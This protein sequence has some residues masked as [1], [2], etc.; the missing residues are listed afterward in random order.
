MTRLAE[1]PSEVLLLIIEQFSRQCDISSLAQSSKRLY[2]LYHPYLCRYNVRYD[3]SSALTWAIRNGHT[4]L[5]GQ[6]QDGG[7]SLSTFE[8]LSPWRF[9]DSHLQ[10][11]TNPLLLAA[12]EGRREVF[13]LL[14]TWPLPP[15]LL[16]GAFHW[17][18]YNGHAELV[19][20]MIQNNTSLDR[21]NTKERAMSALGTAVS[22]DNVQ[23]ASRLL[24]AGGHIHPD[25]LPKPWLIATRNPAML[26]LLL[27]CGRRPLSD[28]PVFYAAS[29]DNEPALQLF[30]D[31][32]FNM[33]VYGHGALVEAIEL[34]LP[35]I[36]KFL[37]EHGA[38][39]HLSDAYKAYKYGPFPKRSTIWLAVRK[40]HLEVLQLLLENGVQPDSCDLTLAKNMRF[41]GAISLLSQFSFEKV[42]QRQDIETFV[43]E[44]E[45]KLSEKF[46]NVDPDTY[47]PFLFNPGH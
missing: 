35:K 31:Y 21:R 27:K 41:H 18:I 47:M 44:Q 1:L 29:Y 39:P 16:H 8:P 15:T 26:E 33:A 5:L 3:R 42:R 32:G 24:E 23:M 13:E 9:S 12:K 14:I 7:A 20:L 11:L 37:I 10:T 43:R 22:S 28:H 40:Q 45:M 25:E 34:G 36:V 6:L 38:N 30:I 46:P 4:R 17:S 2:N 19:D